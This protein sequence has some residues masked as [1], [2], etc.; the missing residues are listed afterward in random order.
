MR[1]RWWVGLLTVLVVI[2]GSLAAQHRSVQ[3]AGAEVHQE[4]DGD[5]FPPFPGVLDDPIFADLSPPAPNQP[6]SLGRYVPPP[7]GSGAEQSASVDPEGNGAVPNAPATA[8]RTLAPTVFLERI[9]TDAK[10]RILLIGNDELQ[11]G[12]GRAD[13][14]VVLTFDPVAQ[15][16]TFLSVPRDTRTLIPDYGVNKINAAYAFGGATRQTLAVERF[17]G[18]PM[19]KFVEISMTGF[20]RSIDLVGGV[21]VNPPFAFEL[22]GQM[23]QPGEIRLNGTQALAYIRMRKEDPHGDL[24]RN[25]RQQEVLR[26][27]IAELSQRSPDELNQL[28][29]QLQQEV[30]T[31]FSPSEVL[32]LR[33][34]HA[35][36]VDHQTVLEVAGTHQKIDGL[37]YYVVSDQERQ[38]L[39]LSLR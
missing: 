5:G 2:A 36:A 11:L 27:L 31:N 7:S 21:T 17:L 38:R 19:D 34:Q 28:L 20:E 23:F 30:R 35:Y 14:L 29:Q 25:S 13:V 39:H 26:S 16:L 4:L 37:W 1:R 10:I 15:M 33:V 18:L 22:D 9:Q 32:E 6:T 8:G 12:E 3:Q 24:G